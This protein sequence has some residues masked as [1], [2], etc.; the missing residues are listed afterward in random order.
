MNKLLR[1]LPISLIPLLLFVSNCDDRVPTVSQTDN[2]QITVSATSVSSGLLVGEDIVGPQASTRVSALVTDTDGKPVK[3]VLVAF[4]GSVLGTSYGT[5]DISSD[6]TDEDGIVSVL[7]SDGQGS[8]AVDDVNTEIFEG[9]KVTARINEDKFAF[10]KFNVYPS[11][12]TVWPYK[13]F[14]SSNVGSINLDNGVTKALIDT[15]LLNKLNKPVPNVTLSYA[16]NKGYIDTEGTTDATGSIQKDFVDLGIQSDIGVANIIASFTHPGAMTNSVIKDSVQVTITTEFSLSVQS[17]P[18]SVDDDGNVIVVGE[19]V[20]GDSA[21]TM[22]VATVL[23]TAQ[24]PITGAYLDFT[25]RVSGVEVGTVTVLNHNTNSAGQ[26]IAFFDDGGN[27]YRD[28]LGTPNYEGVILT[29]N[30]GEEIITTTKFNVYDPDDVWPYSLV[31]NTNTDVIYVDNGGTFAEITIRLLNALGVPVKNVEVAYEVNHGFINAT[32]VTNSAGIDTVYFTD[33]GDPDD[34]GITNIQARFVHPGFNQTINN[35]VQVMIEDNTFGTCAYMQIPPSNPG[36]IVVKDGGG[37]ESTFIRARVYDDEGHLIDTPTLVTFRMEPPL[38]GALLNETGVG[39][40]T[41]TVNGIASVTVNSGT[42][43]GPVR[44]VV[45]VD[46]DEDGTADLTSIAVPVIIASGAPFYL[47]PE[48]DPASTAPTGGGFYQTQAAAL[49]YDRWYNPVEDSTYVY[50]TIDPIPPDTSI[51]A[52]VDGVS[53][54]NNPNVAGESYPGIAFTKIRYATDAIG[55]FGRVTATTF[56]ANGDTITSAINDDDNA[57]MFFV[58]GVVNLTTNIQYYDFT[59]PVPTTSVTVL[60]TARVYDYYGNEVADAPLS[61]GGIGVAA[62]LEVGY[63]AYTDEGVNGYGVGD[64]CFTWRDYGLD[65]IPGT[66]DIGE[67]NNDHDALASNPD[68]AEVSEP[69]LDYGIDGMPDTFDEGEN[70]GEWNGYHMIGCLPLVKT[71]RFG[72]AKIMAVFPRELCIWQ[73]TDEVTGICTFD[74]FTGII[75]STLLIPEITSSDPV[76]IQLTRSPT[77]IGCP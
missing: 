16:T 75:S 72:V 55:D 33:L 36:H 38:P 69:F 23:D 19:D 26:V 44:V 8:G 10:V 7:Y 11:L 64:G 42:H 12:E 57:V 4:T 63:E 60:V 48:Y 53:Y 30:Y 49:V 74:D 56:G 27:V 2:Y 18:V 54:T 22:V 66:H 20:A 41:Y 34:V 3:D 47:E 5:F 32:G 65:N 15:R 9:V 43:P 31:I 52:E 51:N 50:W 70:D 25:A 71:D 59:L 58:P 21:V 77:N 24:N 6:L 37:L 17:Y 62:W 73:A 1:L 13:L 40:S 67:G 39:V 46:C 45:T 68:S 35:S 61:F 28:A 14:I 29:V 76:E